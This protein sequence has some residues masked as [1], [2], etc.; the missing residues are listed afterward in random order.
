MMV[1]C[2]GM[3]RKRIR[4]QKLGELA[5]SEGYSCGLEVIVVSLIECDQVFARHLPCV[6]HDYHSASEGIGRDTLDFH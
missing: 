4:K 1:R 2:A 3:R 5:L 6:S